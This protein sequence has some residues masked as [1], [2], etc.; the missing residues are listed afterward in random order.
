MNCIKGFT[1]ALAA[2]AGLAAS[3]GRA[4]D[5]ALPVAAAAPAAAACAGQASLTNEQ[6]RIVAH[7]DAGFASLRRF[8]LRTRMI[9]QLDVRET[10]AW[11]DALRARSALCGQRI[12]SVDPVA[13]AP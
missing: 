2:I 3:P 9:Y 12:A 8:V 11:V 13:V 1:I 7:A 4:Q 10:A 5:A 6:R